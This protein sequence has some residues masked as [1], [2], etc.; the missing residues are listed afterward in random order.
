MQIT[1]CKNEDKIINY[2][3]SSLEGLKPLESSSGVAIFT[4]SLQTSGITEVS[5]FLF[6]LR[7]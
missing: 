4:T 3:E 7:Q 1:V 2:Q 6:L 5:P